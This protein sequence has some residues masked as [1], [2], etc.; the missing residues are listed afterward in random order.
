LQARAEGALPELLK[1]IV[2]GELALELGT[3][4]HQRG[5]ALHRKIKDL[6][7]KHSFNL[8]A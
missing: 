6:T 5:G 4:P 8:Q 1:L 2:V 7:G 3:A